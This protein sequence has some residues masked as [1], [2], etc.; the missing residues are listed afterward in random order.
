MDDEL[1]LVLALGEQARAEQAGQDPDTRELAREL[2]GA[3]VD[4]YH[5]ANA[6]E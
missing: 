4:R 3:Q 5:A 1:S 2:L 6:P